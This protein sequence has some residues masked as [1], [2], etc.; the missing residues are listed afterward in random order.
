MLAFHQATGLLPGLQPLNEF[1]KQQRGAQLWQDIPL[2]SLLLCD[3]I[4]A[5]NSFILYAPVP[6]TRQ[7]KSQLSAREAAFVS[8]HFLQ[9]LLQS[10]AEP[11]A[12]AAAKHA[13]ELRAVIGMHSGSGSGWRG[14]TDG[15]KRMCAR[16]APQA[17]QEEAASMAAAARDMHETGVCV[18]MSEHGKWSVLQRLPARETWLTATGERGARTYVRVGVRMQALGRVRLLSMAV[19]WRGRQR[20]GVVG[21]RKAP[22]TYNSAKSKCLLRATVPSLSFRHQ[23]AAIPSSFVLLLN[24]VQ[25]ASVCLHPDVMCARARFR[26]IYRRSELVDVG[27]HDTDAFRRLSPYLSD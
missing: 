25:C 22:F 24:F 14:R 19:T 12:A 1:M 9:K 2:Q 11:A 17:W 27:V 7:L 3:Y 26:F 16:A 5:L 15:F 6:T 23:R 13:M 10:A 8:L 4:T 20:C 18:R 21:P